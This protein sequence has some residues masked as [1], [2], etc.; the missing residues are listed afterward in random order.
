MIFTGCYTRFMTRTLDAAIAKL[1]SLPAEEQDRVGKWL[2]EEL[3]DEDRWAADFQG[4][5]DTLNKLAE[6]ARDD[7][8]Y[9]RATDFDP[10]KI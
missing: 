8:A 5:Q 6:E 10:D 7:L 9:G 4:S 3:R 2:L 1:A